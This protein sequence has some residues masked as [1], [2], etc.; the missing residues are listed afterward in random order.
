MSFILTSD[1]LNLFKVDYNEGRV[2]SFKVSWDDNRTAKQGSLRGDPERMEIVMIRSKWGLGIDWLLPQLGKDFGYSLGM[3]GLAY[4]PFLF[5]SVLCVC[6]CVLLCTDVLAG[7][8]VQ[9]TGE[10]GN[11]LFIVL[12]PTSTEG[13]WGSKPLALGF[14]RWSIWLLKNENYFKFVFLPIL[15]EG[16]TKLNIWFYSWSLKKCFGGLVVCQL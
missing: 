4:H 7:E 9:L 1:T 3:T 6:L 11:I 15:Q 10:S 12:P 16:L 2:E 8:S 14:P 5:L 13:P